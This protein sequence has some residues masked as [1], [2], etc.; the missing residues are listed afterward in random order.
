MTEENR[1]PETK[2]LRAAILGSIWASAEIIIGSFLHNIKLPFAGTIL[3]SFAVFL[4]TAFDRSWKQDGVIIRAGV[5][6]ALMKSVSPSSVIFGPMIGITLEALMIQL[7][8]RLFGHNLFGYVI[9]GALAVSTSFFQKLIGLVISYGSSIVEIYEG[10]VRYSAKSLSL[11]F[12]NPNSPIIAIL[13]IYLFA[14]AIAA[15]I[16]WRAAGVGPKKG[17]MRL[18]STPDAAYLSAGDFKT[19]DFK[20]GEPSVRHSIMMIPLFI[21]LTAAG[22][23]LITLGSFIY[24]ALYVAAFLAFA[25][26]RY[27]RPALRLLNPRFFS[28]L[29][30]IAV[31]AGLFLGRLSDSSG[32]ISVNGLISG[33]EMGLRAVMLSCAFRCIGIELGAPEIRKWF[34]ERAS[35]DFLSA[36]ELSFQTL[37]A[38]LLMLNENKK[39]IVSPAGFISG[40]ISA[41]DEW[42]KKNFFSQNPA[43]S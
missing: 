16:G 21:L 19:G 34:E 11:H 32:W 33:A 38:L 6:C 35:K 4:L 3:A 8:I 12:T 43:D 2:W 30:I 40:Y 17:G 31:L 41:A 26:V 22:M 14:G 1:I 42:I 23:Y 20:T 15:L 36:L 5:I 10:I 37:P 13:C 39:M 28:E 29:L 7:M 25:A 24:P 9:G 18:N 27:G